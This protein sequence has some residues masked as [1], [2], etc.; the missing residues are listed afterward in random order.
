MLLEVKG[1]HIAYG[2]IEAVSGVNFRLEEGELVSIIGANGAGKT[3]IL[4]ALM[5][6]LPVKAGAI[7]FKGRDITTMASHER[8]RIGIRMV[9]ERS[10]L[11]PRL[12]VYENLLTGVYGLKKKIPVDKRIDW[13]YGIFPILK[14]RSGQLATTL[15]GGEQQQLS[16]ARALISDPELLLVDEVSMGLMPKLVEQVFGVLEQLNREQGLTILL[17]EQN[18]FASLSISKRGYVLETGSCV[19]EGHARDLLV[20]P[21]VKEVYLGN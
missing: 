2:D 4:S 12:T 5:G 20:D 18:A 3:S 15:S 17:V 14:E 1:I 8:A 11:F 6:I 10:R 16:I 9:P 21:R 13:L 19:L 7:F